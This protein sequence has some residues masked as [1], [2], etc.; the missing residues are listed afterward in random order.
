MGGK[1]KVCKI[2]EW[3]A[4]HKLLLD[5]K[6]PCQ[7]L[8][9]HTYKVEFLIKGPINKN[10]MVIDFSLFKKHINERCSFDHKYL[11]DLLDQPTAEN[12]VEYLYKLTCKELLVIR[13]VYNL[14]ISLVKV[15]VWETPT[16]YAEENY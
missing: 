16:S 4:A 8:H 14:N 5:Y 13:K 15:R 10:G 1:M 6:S 11:N 12:L 3:D 7:G 9:G 2:F